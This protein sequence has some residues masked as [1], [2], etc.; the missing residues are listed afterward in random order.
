M[1]F[2][3]KI[4]RAKRQTKASFTLLEIMITLSVIA[5][6]G[7]F[8]AF[9]ASSMI[10]SRHF[11]ESISKVD[12]SFHLLKSAAVAYRCDFTLSLEQKEGKVFFLIETTSEE[13]PEK[14]LTQEELKGVSEFYQNPNTPLKKI[15][16]H[17]YSSGLIAPK[18]KL[19]LQAEKGDEKREIPLS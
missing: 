12:R 11:K 9:G 6:I 10:A 19:F 16:Y 15:Q 13:V 1:M 18:E 5:L 7:S 14:F 17:I 3:K 2:P 4:K 8:L